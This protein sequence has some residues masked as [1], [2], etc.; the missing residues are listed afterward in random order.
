MEEKGESGSGWKEK[1]SGW[2]RSRSFVFYDFLIL[3]AA[4]IAFL[5]LWLSMTRASNVAMF[6]EFYSEGFSATYCLEG[7][8]A[9]AVGSGRLEIETVE[10]NGDTAVLEVTAGGMKKRLT[11]DRKT[12]KVTDGELAGLP[13]V[14]YYDIVREPGQTSKTFGSNKEPAFSTAFTG[15]TG[16][17]SA[18]IKESNPDNVVMWYHESDERSYGPQFSWEL[19]LHDQDGKRVG[20]IINDVTSGVLLDAR[21]YQDGWGAMNLERTNYPT[22][23]NRWAIFYGLNSILILW[24]IFHLLRCRKHREE[25]K[26]HWSYFPLGF[27]GISSF[28]IRL[29]AFT[30]FGFLGI[31]ILTGDPYIL[32]VT[33]LIGLTLMIYAVGI[34]A[35][36]IVFQFIP[37][38]AAYGVFAGGRPLDYIQYPFGVPLYLVA[39][40]MFELHRY[41]CHKEK[42]GL[43]PI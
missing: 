31:G 5:I 7:S 13:L 33:D 10:V 11:V 24:G 4:I 16:D 6:G 18:R 42:Q 20:T 30:V 1:I 36:P 21:F 43:P 41:L 28:Y 26:S 39:V 29:M 25:W 23:L 34:F 38:I 27:V 32:L 19:Q 37:W 8:A 2:L 14:F 40:V 3:A 9:R 15:L 17:V 35:F 22:G 12:A